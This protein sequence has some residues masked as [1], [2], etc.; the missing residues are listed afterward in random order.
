MTDRLTEAELAQIVEHWTKSNAFVPKRHFDR[1]IAAARL[2]NEQAELLNDVRGDADAVWKVTDIG[3][4]LTELKRWARARIA[5]CQ[6]QELKFGNLSGKMPQ[7]LIEAWT[8]RR[9]LQSVLDQLK[10]PPSTDVNQQLAE[11]DAT[12]KQQAERIAGL[13][14]RIADRISLDIACPPPY[15]L[16]RSVT[17]P[18]IAKAACILGVALNRD[19][20]VLLDGL[21]E[22]RLSDRNATIESQA[23][24]LRGMTTVAATRENER[25]AAR[26]ALDRAKALVQHMIAE[27]D[28][29]IVR[30]LRWI[31][32]AEE[33]DR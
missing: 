14:R 10:A 25:D 6:K 31:E 22:D 30:E 4:R 32:R 2:A 23:A 9:A 28:P 24:L 16:V 11:R 12:I 18:Q 33:L 26:A 20:R 5:E 27:S 8:E 7:A 3:I 13:E 17:D 21:S 15:E 19:P 1:L 29:D